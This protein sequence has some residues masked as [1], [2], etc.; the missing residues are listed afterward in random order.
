MSEAWDKVNAAAQALKDAL[1]KAAHT[2]PAD[3]ASGV[4]SGAAQVGKG[5]S[6]MTKNVVEAAKRHI[7]NALDWVKRGIP[8]D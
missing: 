5:A 2:S 4:A 8:G 3:V 7:D 6:E 1:D